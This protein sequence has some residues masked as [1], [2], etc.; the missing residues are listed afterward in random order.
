MTTNDMGGFVCND[1]G[2]FI[3]ASIAEIDEGAADEQVASGK[4]D[5][6]GALVMHQ[7]TVV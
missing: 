6:A 7:F 3:D 1:E 2:Y 5:R 4:A